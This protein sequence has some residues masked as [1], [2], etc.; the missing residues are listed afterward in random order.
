MLGR[1]ILKNLIL[2]V[3]YKCM[4]T[5]LRIAIFVAVTT[6]LACGPSGRAG[7]PNHASKPSSNADYPVFVALA[8]WPN[9]PELNDKEGR[10]VQT[11][12]NEHKIKN[13]AVGSAGMTLNVME[14]Q[15][16]EA[17]KLLAKAVL[18]ENLQILLYDSKG[19]EASPKDILG[20]KKRQ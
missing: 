6:V 13:A 9:T 7:N 18:A 15:A 11:I 5:L 8:G 2:P 1:N 16:D 17:R 3:S 14:P 20:H 12:L 10:R 19:K 4:K